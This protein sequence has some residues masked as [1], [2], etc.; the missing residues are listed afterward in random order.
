MADTDPR[1]PFAHPNN[2]FSELLASLE[3]NPFFMS[4]QQPEIPN[5]PSTLSKLKPKHG[6][7]EL[8]FDETTQAAIDSILEDLSY[9]EEL[10]KNDLAP[11]KKILLH[12]PTGCG[13]TSIA[14][15]FAK[16]LGRPLYQQSIAACS[17]K[18]V[19]ETEKNFA[20]ML[21]YAQK[22]NCVLLLDEADAL[23]SN[24]IDSVASGYAHHHNSAVN[25]FLVEFEKVEPK[26]LIIAC[27]NLVENI[28]SAIRRRFDAHIR[29]PSATKST[30]EKVANSVLKGRFG[31]SY[32]SLNITIQ[33]NPSSVAGKSRAA[34]RT[35]II[36]LAKAK[37]TS[38][39]LGSR[40]NA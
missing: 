2:P 25:S 32:E 31:L 23:L 1:N 30:L 5:A 28:D 15:A 40:P 17:S 16:L 10:R 12:G 34:L 38:N 37:K 36:E 9:E 39:K 21:A 7:D 35:K 33:D 6:F 8:T 24:R 20:T 22:T 26:G 14:H 13:K 18:Y 19:G 11:C 29:V 27:T 3:G 4:D